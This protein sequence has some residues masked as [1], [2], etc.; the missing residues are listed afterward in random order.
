MVGQMAPLRTE[1][2]MS[3]S[4][5]LGALGAGGV[6]QLLSSDTFPVHHAG[7]WEC[8]GGVRAA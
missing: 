1:V 3:G 2:A 4:T 5:A 7:T 8:G 6:P